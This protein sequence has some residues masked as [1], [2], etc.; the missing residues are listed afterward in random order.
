M[1]LLSLGKLAGKRNLGYIC[2]MIIG[3]DAKRAVSNMT[4]LG[5]YSRFI[6]ES[7][8]KEYPDNQLLLFTPKMAENPRL[9]PLHGH[10][11]TFITPSTP[12][13]GGLCRRGGLMSKGSL[14]RTWGVSR[15]LP[16][17]NVALYHGLSNE[18]PLNI[19]DS[20]VPSVVTIHDVIYRRL[21]QCYTLPDRLIYDFKYGRSCR[22]A[23]HIIAISE[24]TKQDI[25][26]LY[27]VAEEKISVV[28]QGCDKSFSQH[29]EEYEVEKLRR[30]LQLPEQFILQVG[31]IEERKN[32]ML[33]VRT[34]PYLPDDVSLVAL[35]RGRLGYKEK[36]LREAQRLGVLQRVRI[37]DNLPFSRLPLLYRAAKVSVYPSRYEGFGI[38][39]LESL[40]SGTPVVGATGSC[41]EEAGGRA[42]LYV[43]PDDVRG[44]SEA[45]KTLLHDGNERKTR[46][47]EGRL[48][49]AKFDNST[50]AANTMKAYQ[51][52]LKAHNP[53]EKNGK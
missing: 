5:N 14:W 53:E 21:P 52:A 4:G 29:F 10:D 33:T 40:S 15:E 43:N 32:L 12:L 36:V 17:R 27:G 38:P 8:A 46:I 23:D 20:G 24:R 39:I 31:T 51:R 34:L 49:A 11:I 50:V 18:L 13:S 41:L 16:A 47:E 2:S 7:V 28:Y 42:A 44:M 45:I 6:I 3:Y 22:N 1:E 37:L 19:R 48:H 30:D 9:A 26:E 25:M 35:G